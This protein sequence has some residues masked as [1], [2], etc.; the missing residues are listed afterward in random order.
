MSDSSEK[1]VPC[2]RSECR[3][4]CFY[5]DVCSERPIAKVSCVCGSQL[6]MPY[7]N[8]TGEHSTTECPAPTED[9]R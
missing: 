6:V 1:A 4:G 7:P 2:W 8:D 9:D 3:T 5:P